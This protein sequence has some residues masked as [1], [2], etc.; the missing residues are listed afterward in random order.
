MLLDVIKNKKFE[1]YD[2]DLARLIP[3]S[4]DLNVDDP[5]C[6]QLA[7][8]IRTFYFEG[9]KITAD[10]IKPLIDLMTDYHFA[11]SMHLTAELYALHQR[12]WVVGCVA[13]KNFI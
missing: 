5:R 6:Q 13:I 2:R 9:R 1:V 12:R 10:T 3:K 4:I 11:L 7:N 8:E